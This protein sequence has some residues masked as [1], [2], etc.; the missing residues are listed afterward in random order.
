MGQRATYAAFLRAVNLGATRKL[1]MA[2]VREVLADVLGYESVR[3]YIASGNV[4]FSVAAGAA[5]DD[6]GGGG[7]SGVEGIAGGEGTDEAAARHAAAIGGT[8]TELAGF[9]VPAVVLTPAAL[10]QVLAEEPYD[11]EIAKHVNVGLVQG[12]VA[13]QTRRRL[14]EIADRAVDGEGLTVGERA[15]YLHLP[16]SIHGSK[17]AAAYARAAPEATSRN[18]ATVR[19]MAE[20]LPAG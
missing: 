14:A 6:V 7:E 5:E 9:D 10:A 18:L 8:L 19:K 15:V 12:F 4:V 3:T 20:L 13:A 17:L 11:P 16:H 2:R 1:P